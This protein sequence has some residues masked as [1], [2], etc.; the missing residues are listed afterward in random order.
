[1]SLL[2]F[3]KPVRNVFLEP[4]IAP[5]LKLGK[6]IDYIPF[7]ERPGSPQESFQNNVFR[8][9]R[10]FDVPWHLRWHFMYAMLGDV[11]IKANQISRRLPTG[12]SIRDFTSIY[13]RL[14]TDKVAD[15]GAENPWLFAT[16][17]DSI[18]GIAFDGKDSMYVGLT[19]E[20]LNGDI[21]NAHKPLA[22]STVPINYEPPEYDLSSEFSRTKP[23]KTPKLKSEDTQNFYQK[24][25]NTLQR[26]RYIREEM[27]NHDIEVVYKDV[28]H[29]LK[30]E[31][32]K[33]IRE[34]KKDT[35]EKKAEYK[36]Y[37]R[38]LKK[39]NRIPLKTNF[40]A[41]KQTIPSRVQATNNATVPG[42]YPEGTLATMIT[43]F[44]N[45]DPTAICKYKLARITVSFEN[46][47][48][49]I[50][51]NVTIK[52]SNEGKEEL[53]NDIFTTFFRMPTAEFLSLP[54]GAYRYVHQDT[55]KRYVVQGS[56]MRL[57]AQ[58]EILLSWHRVPFI[59][60]SVRTAIGSVN[61]DWFP[62]SH[63]ALT[64]NREEF[65]LNDRIWAAPGTLLLTNVEIKP[66]KHFFSRRVYDINY[67]FKYFHATEQDSTGAL[68]SAY[69]DTN[70]V[71]AS[72][73]CE[74]SL[75]ERNKCQ[76]QAK[77]HNYF[78]KYL[79]VNVPGKETNDIK[80]TTTV[81]GVTTTT[82]TA[83][84]SPFSGTTYPPCALSGAALPTEKCDPSKNV[85]LFQYELITHDGCP[86]G[87][88]VYL[89][90][91]F[92]LLFKAPA[93]NHN[94]CK[95]GANGAGATGHPALSNLAP[96]T[97][98]SPSLNRTHTL[99]NFATS[100]NDKHKPTFVTPSVTKAKTP[101]NRLRK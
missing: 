33:T 71:I 29:E 16:S 101:N 98:G 53:L 3:K 88:P 56:N 83:T 47:P 5:M 36:H 84:A 76:K 26:L 44:G 94:N 37:L 72:N 85:S 57:V 10:V 27:S 2:P 58:E 35:E 73:P 15:I 9:R 18:E 46:S 60:D 20:Q 64:D 23:R 31:E 48:F 95:E 21:Y 74:P 12:Y 63:L 13:D 40:N 90:S 70:T 78:L 32:K 45:V 8:V 89:S 28:I 61:D 87:R 17:I 65:D 4:Y 7:A 100:V 96:I 81:S 93:T 59:P 99:E 51:S 67:K 69:S 49:R 92:D 42:A 66:Y 91:D 6:T 79:F 43:S 62:I 22:N 41:L 11:G 86:S 24:K 55:S 38:E 30:Q 75:R 52:T 1:M 14:S 54:F 25:E 97:N 50:L 34:S 82:T 19:K 77:G 39:E 80:T 68:V